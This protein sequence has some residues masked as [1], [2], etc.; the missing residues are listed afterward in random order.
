MRILLFLFLLL[1]YSGIGQSQLEIPFLSADD[2]IIRHHAYSVSYN[3]TYGQANW[4]AYQL[5]KLELTGTVKRTNSFKADPL[6]V[7]TNLAVDYKGSGY[8]RGHLA[9]AADMGFSEV[10][11]RES[12]YYSN[13][14]PQVPGFNRG[15]WK[16]LEEQTRDWTSL[17]DSLYIVVGAVFSD[18]MKVIG[19]HRVAVPTY[20]YKVILDNKLGQE[21]AIGFLMENVGSSLPIGS[22]VV[23]IDEIER[24]TGID[25]FPLLE[26]GLEDEL[27]GKVCLSCWDI[28]T[29]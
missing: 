8:D 24:L 9:P 20:Y 5:T 10:T 25:F 17:Y 28:L 15:I 11:M 29:R 2:T 14:S 27:E 1:A 16:K 7:G 19:P 3:S 12:F 23:A 13:M 22:F 4:V 26:D 21:K 18:S 6:I